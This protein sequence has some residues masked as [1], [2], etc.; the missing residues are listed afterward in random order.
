MAADKDY[1]ICVIGGG[2]AG[3]VAAAGA[4][5]LGAKV[6]LVEQNKLG[7]DCLYS[8]CV[9]S[10]T[11]IHS[12]S[13]AY[14][15]RHAER[16]GLNAHHEDIDQHLVMQRVA[17]VIKHIEPNDSP[18][19]FRALGVEVVLE[20]A[21]FLDQQTLNVADRQV[22][23]KR[24]I[25][26]TGSQPSI[27]DIPGLDT[28][29]YLTNESIFHVN[30]PI[31]HLVIVGAGPIG[32][33]LAQ[34][35]A[36]LGVQVSLVGRR[37]RLLPREDADMAE[38]V[39]QQF[40]VDGVGLYLNTTVTK[41][42]Q[43]E[44]GVRVCLY[45]D[46]QRKDQK[47][48]EGSHLL[49][50]T[51]RQSSLDSL[52]LEKAGI[53]LQDGH[54]RVDSR[55]RTTNKRIYACGDVVGPYLFTHMAEHQAKVVLQNALFHLPIKVKT[56][57]IPWCTFTSPELARVGLSEQ[58]A[59][60]QGIQHQIYSFPFSDIDRAITDGETVGM[61]KIIT[62]PRGRIL[63]ASIVGPH[64]GELIAEYALAIDRRLS[65]SAVSKVIHI[66]PTLAQI[67]RQVADQRLRESLTNN[68]KRWLKRLF[69]LRGH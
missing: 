46:D 56:K 53:E 22:T 20:K 50:A 5:T 11:L 43:A 12:A 67:N 64:A 35:F 68:K 9:P 26:A 54:L 4:A 69:G 58:E 30:E 48:L 2:A 13:V 24:F 34:A 8:G 36:R 15:I 37:S 16:F 31:K 49:V 19:H 42:E 14:A 66:Y 39:K 7:G 41:V 51:G 60:Q 47:W 59:Q 33:E 6:L 57:G 27:P 63:G 62:S 38:I 28:V 21:H 3:L 44:Q 25:I 40:L 29:D 1:D 23:A 18:E 55:L 52:A 65:L 10:K 61:A 17:Q 32:C 45:G